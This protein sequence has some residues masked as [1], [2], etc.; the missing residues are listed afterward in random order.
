MWYVRSG[1]AY[2][3][4]GVLVVQRGP[5]LTGVAGDGEHHNLCFVNLLLLKDTE[6]LNYK[7][8]RTL[9]R[10]WVKNKSKSPSLLHFTE[11][12][13]VIL[14]RTGCYTTFSFFTF[15]FFS[16]AKSCFNFMVDI[17]YHLIWVTLWCDWRIIFFKLASYVYYIITW[18]QVETSF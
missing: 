11:A 4:D 9:F 13:C 15:L 16:T 8:P 17:Y 18:Y 2:S 10:T 5:S 3:E 7:H 12:L 6:W 14:N 1:S